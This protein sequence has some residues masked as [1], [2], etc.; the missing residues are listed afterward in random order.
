[1][2]TAIGQPYV[3]GNY[4]EKTETWHE[5]DSPYKAKIIEGALART[6]VQFNSIADIGCGAGLVI[7]LI[8]QSHPNATCAG[9]ELSHDVQPFWQKRTPLPN[10]RYSHDNIMEL[11][12]KFDLITCLD[13]FEHVEDYFGF[14]RG[15]RNSGE[16]FIFNVP[17]DMNVMKILTSGIRHAREDAGHLHYFN[18]YTAKQTIIDAGYEIIEARV[19]AAFLK[20]PPRNIRQMAV[21]PFRIATLAFGKTFSASTFGGMSMLVTA[22]RRP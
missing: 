5:E 7:E 8:A 1:M 16:Y 22:R 2:N 13:V 21:L 10:L 12:E 14:L 6:G 15:L 18:P 4:L 19:E 11:G 17:L 9:F 3:D 20:V